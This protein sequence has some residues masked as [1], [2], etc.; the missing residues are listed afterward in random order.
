MFDINNY[1]K[2]DA[3]YKYGF[4][5]DSNL[6]CNDKN[7]LKFIKNKI[8]NENKQIICIGYDSLSIIKN[9]Y[10]NYC[11]IT[12]K[13]KKITIHEKPSADFL[14][15]KNVV[16]KGDSVLNCIAELGKTKHY[17]NRLISLLDLNLSHLDN[18]ISYE[19]LFQIDLSKL[20]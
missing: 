14:L 18:K 11:L 15:F 6:I 2:K 5:L 3:R 1:L 4:F 12:I 20:T 16:S 17:A 9:F 8:D 10:K 19:W 13:E 7:F